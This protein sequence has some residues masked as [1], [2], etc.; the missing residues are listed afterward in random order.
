MR[1]SD[2]PYSLVAHVVYNWWGQWTT[3]GRVIKNLANFSRHYVTLWPRPLTPWPSTFVVH[4]MSRVQNF[5]FRTK[6]ERNRTIC[7]WVIDDL[8]N[9]KGVGLPGP[10][11]TPQTAPNLGENI[12]P[13]YRTVRGDT[14]VA[15]F[16]FVT[17]RG[18]RL[19]RSNPVLDGLTLAPQRCLLDP[20]LCDVM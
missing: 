9:F 10:D 14:L 3:C 12:A 20:P 16:W 19:E 18:P 11:S 1:R 15:I 5:K 17:K 8:T 7:G 13:S 4:K 2:L 6:F